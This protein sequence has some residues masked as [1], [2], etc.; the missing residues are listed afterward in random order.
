MGLGW[1]GQCS[2]STSARLVVHWVG[3]SDAPMSEYIEDN[4]NQ[5]SHCGRK[6]LPI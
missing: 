5:V 2:G 3:G 6:E 1:G 4:G